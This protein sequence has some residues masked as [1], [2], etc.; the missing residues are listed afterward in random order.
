[1]DEKSIKELAGTLQM[2]LPETDLIKLK[3]SDGRT[4]FINA[5][6]VKEFSLDDKSND[7]LSKDS[8]T[9]LA[10]IEFSKKT[11]ETRLRMVYMQTGIQWMPSYFIKIQDDKEL[12][13]EL[14][15]LVE[16]YSENIEDAD[17]TL[18]VG[19]PQFYWGNMTDPISLDYL[20]NIFD[21]KSANL[22]GLS[23]Q[24]QNYN[25]TPAQDMSVAQMPLRTP[26]FEESSIYSTEG[27]KTNDLFM[28]TLGKVSLLKDTKTS[29]EIFSQKVNYK[30]VYE[31]NINDV[32]NYSTN[33]YIAN[34][35]EA[36]QDV[37]HS[38]RL[39]NKTNNPFTTAPAFVL[40][41][42]QQPLAQ[43]IIKYTSVGSDVSIQLSKAADVIV[44]NQEEEIKKVENFKKVGRNYY[45]KVSIKG[46]ISISNLQKKS[47]D[48]RV[49]KS[50]M[51][52]VI[53]ASDNGKSKKSG[54]YYSLNPYSDI[55]WEIPIKE[56]E[57]K[58]ITYQYDVL[59]INN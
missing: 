36:R 47:I 22:G 48:L 39:T 28:Y 43:D 34:D 5:S 23:Y 56:N 46:T 19:N 9:R 33:K 45:N 55:N 17:L 1:M 29:F 14:K 27:E 3:G 25:F 50:L 51:A 20:S 13:I 4:Y 38:L 31:V 2:Y 6:N 7:Y 11:D 53:E 40:N 21:Q 59:V 52:E 24:F 54:K 32:V 57:K 16:N 49:K 35:P 37:F 18:T 10:E 42:K 44:K 30:D 15:A 12:I 58:V 26:A 41:E 8:L